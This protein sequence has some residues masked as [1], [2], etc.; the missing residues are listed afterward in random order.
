ML[1]MRWLAPLTVVIALVGTGCDT[2]I[3]GIDDGGSGPAAKP[4]TLIVSETWV[5]DHQG[6]PGAGGAAGGSDVQARLTTLQSGIDQLRDETGTGWVGRQDDVTGYLSELSGG[7]WPGTPAAF[8]DGYGPDLF[9]VGS[10]VLRIGEPDS[11]TVPGI[12]TTKATQAVGDVSVVDASLVFVE[13][14]GRVT[15]VRGR[16]Y[17]GLTV[18]TTATVP[19]DQAQAIAEQAAAGTAQATPSLVVMPR[20]AGVLAWLVPV[21]TTGDLTTPLAAANYYI[22]A[23]TG[24]I[25]SV[26]QVSGEGRVAL[27]FA[28]SAARYLHRVHLSG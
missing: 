18:S 3:D 25:L 12:V 17:P 23:T 1:R 24:D 13:R 2:G 20:G 15:G 7:S 16:V 10:D 11:V 21:A 5:N 26:Q 28:A 4:V 27:P 6:D 19:A 22:D 9:G 8:M 14:D